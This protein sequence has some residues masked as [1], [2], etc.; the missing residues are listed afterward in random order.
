MN[1]TTWVYLSSLMI[2]A[3]YFKFHRVLSVRNL[4]LLALLTFSPALLIIARG[5]EHSGYVWM[6]SVSGF[7]LL[8]LLLDPLMV[9]RPL[10]EPNMSASGLTFAGVA[11]LVFLMTNVLTGKV[12]DQDLRTAYRPRPS[13]SGVARAEFVPPADYKPGFRPFH[14]FAESDE[15]I[16]VGEGASSTPQQLSF[17]RAIRRAAAVFG[18]LAVVIGMVLV[19]YRHFDNAHTGVA[20]ASLYLLLPYSAQLTGEIDHVI[21]GAVLVWAAEAY[22][23]PAWA[24]LILGVAAGLVFYPFFLLPLWCA[25]YWRRGLLRFLVALICTLAVMVLLLGFSSSSLG[26][27]GDQLRQMFGWTSFWAEHANGFW[28]HHR[29]AFRIP[30][31]TAFLVLCGSLAMWPAQKNLGTLL[32]LSAAVILAAQFWNPYQGGLYMAWYLPL[33]MLTIFRPN[34]EDRVALTAVVEGRVPGSIRKLLRATMR[35]GRRAAV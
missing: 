20:A 16:A 10:L 19:G 22:R 24:G 9:R 33:L 3:I 21:P 6:F 2:I 27:F 7:F 8:R 11:M 35:T 23:R 12:P 32:S 25:F 28:E 31:I 18:H 13:E 1:P 4:D 17:R 26:A 29:Q 14:I 30:V 15:E 5:H 34:L